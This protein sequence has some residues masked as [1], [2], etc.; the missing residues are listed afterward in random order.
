MKIK[1]AVA[2]HPD[3]EFTVEDVDLIAPNADEILVRLVATGICHT[4]LSVVEQI[5]PLPLPLVLGHE[6][7]GV[8]ESVG[9]NV[10]GYAPG[11]HVVLTFASCGHCAS[12]ADHHPA[13]CE[14]YPLLNFRGARPDGTPTLHDAG[15]EALGGAFFGQSSFAT[16]ALS[17]PLNTIRVR[18][19]APLELLGPLGCGLSTGSGTVINVL[20]PG[21]ATTIAVFGTGAVGMSALMAAKALGAGRIVAVD[22]VESRLAL[23]RELGATDTINTSE[24]NL[25]EALAALGGV[26]QAVDTSGVPALIAAAVGGLKERGTC[27][28]L[29]ASKQT[30]VTLNILP[31]ISG[32]V[33][34]GVVNGDCDPAILIPQ[35]IDWYLEGRF[36]IDKLSAFYP[37][38]RINEA[39]ADSTSGKTIK[40]I[41]TFEAA[42]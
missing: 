36:P 28:L 3:G 7:A 22:R 15:G 1:A 31:L 25:A 24:Q 21:P 4:D 13:Y 35:L 18:K 8:V 27:V 34:R 2:R 23:A 9:A 5:M 19:D 41:L 16:Y 10:T 14:N 20:K 26:D 33:I 42:N 11:D 39:V 40:P 12:C 17:T 37:L 38:D 30:E 6:G 29:G 32:R